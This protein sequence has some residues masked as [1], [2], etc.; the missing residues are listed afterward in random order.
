MTTH[1]THFLEVKHILMSQNRRPEDI[2]QIEQAYLFAAKLHEGQY[3]ISEEPYIIHPIEVAKILADLKMDTHTIVAA[4]LHDILEDTDTSPDEIVKNFGEDVLKLVQGVTKLGKYQFKSK[5]ERQAENFRRMFIAMAEDVR[6]IFLKLAD[7]L[8]NM[9]TL[10]YMAANKQKRIAQETLDIFA[11][12]ANRLGIGKMK[13][14]LEDL[15][16]RYIDPEKYYQIAK[17]VAQTKN[18]RDALVNSLIEITKKHLDENGIKAT[19]YGRAKHYYSIY[20]KMR[21]QNVSFDQLY[22][23][24]AIRVIVDDEKDCYNALGIIHSQFKPIPGRFKDYIAMPKGNMYRSLHTS[25]I[26]L[27]NKPFEIQ[28]RTKEMHEVAE[29]GLAAHWR[30]KES[31]SVK[32][33]NSNDVKFNWMRKLIEISKDETDAKEF[34]ESVKLDL[35]SDQVFTFTPAGDVI[36]LPFGS[37]P[38]DFA[39]RIHT[40][41]GHRTVGALVNGRIVQL[42]TKL[43]NGDIVEIL[44][45]KQ[46]MPKIDWLDFIATK[47]ASGKI[48]AW[49]KKYKREDNVEIGR[50]NLEAELTKPVFDELL[51]SG[52]IDRTAR[53]MNY[54]AADDLFAALGYGETTLRKVLNK[55]QKPKAKDITEIDHQ[56]ETYKKKKASKKND[57]IGLEDMVWSLAKCCSPLP[58]EPIVGVVTRSRGVSVHRLD[59]KCLFDIDPNR[60][61]DIRWADNV[62]QGTYVAHLRIEAQERVGLLKDVLT[63]IADTNTNVSYAYSYSKNKKFGIIDLGIELSDIETLKKIITNLQS[64]QDVLSVR[65]LQQKNDLTQQRSPKKNHKYK[66]KQQK[67]ENS[68]K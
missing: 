63:K 32:A 26:G 41:V 21:R 57:I 43:Q 37:T 6:I 66:Q 49:F 24:V 42:D 12:L 52:E 11:P 46:C 22:D 50:S 62:S 14:E 60:M 67:S 53:E 4:F 59:C 28:I 58:G 2:E 68:D 61:M 13:A 5:E 7:R 65:R 16:L 39:Y 34:V 23:I 36:D 15:S 40:E 45:S 1:L 17:L 35:F 48:R 10:N 47:N 20:N 56:T 64:M 3:R 44:T 38:V 30:Y 19:I 54:K 9:R 27:K 51:K 8:H 31:G 25:V 18:E 55:I 29:Y 33:E